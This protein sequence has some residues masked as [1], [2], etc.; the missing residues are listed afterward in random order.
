MEILHHNYYYI[1][2]CVLCNRLNF[3]NIMRNV[4]IYETNISRVCVVIEFNFYFSKMRK[5]CLKG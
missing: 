5:K 4:L 3:E 1:T 2:P